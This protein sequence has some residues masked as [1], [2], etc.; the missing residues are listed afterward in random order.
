MKKLF[1]ELKQKLE[2]EKKSLEKELESFAKKD[3]SL[4]GDWDTIFPKYNNREGGS[5]AIEDSADEVEEYI[6]M[7]PIEFSLETKL[8][9]I[10]LALEKI[11]AKKEYGKCEQC[12][13]EIP[14]ERLRIVPEAKTCLNCKI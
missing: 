8:K 13:K 5:Q 2:Q 3:P 1:Q 14:E 9:D 6:T 4:K 11:K 7:L 12:K 10:N